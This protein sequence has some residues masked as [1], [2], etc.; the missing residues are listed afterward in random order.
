MR[1]FLL[2]ILLLAALPGSL[3]ADQTKASAAPPMEVRLT[4]ATVVRFASLDEA[5]AL[6]GASDDYSRA[7]GA[8]DRAVRLRTDKP[9]AEEDF[10]KFAASCALA[11]RPEDQRRVIRAIEKLRP[12]FA[13]LPLPLPPVILMIETDG[14]D[15]SDMA[16]TRANAIILPASYFKG[17]LDINYFFAHEA[18][19][20]LTRHAPKI[21]EPLFA[22]IGFRPCGGEP[23]LPPNLE[24]RK[25]TNPDSPRND[26]YCSVV[27]QGA[28]TAA[29][30]VLFSKNP[31]Y[32]SGGILEHLDTKLLAI[33]RR[34]GAWAAR[35]EGGEP[36]LM[37][38]NKVEG[39]Y[40]KTG[41]NTE[42]VMQP[43]EILAD[44]FAY[45]I[46]GKKS[47]P[48]PEVIDAIR[49]EL[50]RFRK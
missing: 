23:I 11:W 5:R 40:E 7:M 30:P 28:A 4:S 12:A 34:D 2:L 21:R 48:S 44:N 27:S 24:S 25:I 19:H 14:R 42:Y 3:P 9:A 45:L 50:Q 20:I 33:E 41:R 22:C 36:L 37:D 38:Y 39:F 26:F 18:F 29:L 32:E 1:C 15:E 17:T 13:Q 6:L 46:T 47:L 35:F 10:L 31:R 8:F 43:E 16:Y 49:R